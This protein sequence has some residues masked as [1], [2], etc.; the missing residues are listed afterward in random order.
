MKTFQFNF[1]PNGKFILVCTV[2]MQVNCITLFQ[3]YTCPTCQSGF[4]EVLENQPEANDES[5]TDMDIVQPF[6]VSV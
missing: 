5:D 3:D 4:I 2:Y 6:D 1:L